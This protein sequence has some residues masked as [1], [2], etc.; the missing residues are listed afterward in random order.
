MI[1]GRRIAMWSGP[2]NLSTAMMRAFENREDCAVVDEPLYAHYLATT[3]VDHPGRDEVIAAGDTDWRRVVERLV[4]PPPGGHAVWY[5]KHMCHHL[6]P[7]MDTAWITALDN[8][9]LIRDPLEVVASYLRT[10]DTCSAEEIGIPQQ[11]A[12]FAQLSSSKGQPPP[13]IDAGAF[14]RN[15]RGHLE[16]LCSVLDIPFSERM[17]RWPPGPRDS[18]GIWAAHWYHVVWA[19]T[20]FAA[21]PRETIDLNPP[22]R[23]IAECCRPAYEHL[24]AHR[25]QP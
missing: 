6:L 23:R 22:G 10:R 11:A 15:P 4:G 12:L 2:R 5:Q 25:L 24:F 17:L 7:G 20:G 3:G 16:A 19:S 9:L 21:P 8:V 1:A 18:D 13:V 14:L